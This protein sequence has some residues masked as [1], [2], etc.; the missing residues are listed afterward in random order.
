[1]SYRIAFGIGLVTIIVT[2][3]L[4]RPLVDQLLMGYFE[5]QY[6]GANDVTLMVNGFVYQLVFIPCLVGFVGAVLS[7]GAC[8]TAVNLNRISVKQAAITVIVVPVVI[9]LLSIL[10]FVLTYFGL[11]F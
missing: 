7:G 4:I 6:A 3:L 10:W 1:M 5:S 9:S 8:W 11:G 2:L